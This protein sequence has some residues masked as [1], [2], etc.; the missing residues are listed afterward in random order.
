MRCFILKHYKNITWTKNK[1]SHMILNQKIKFIWVHKIWRH[2]NSQR[3]LIKSSQ[4]NLQLNKKWVFIYTNLNCHL[5]WKFIQYFM[6]IYYNSQ[7]M[8]QSANRYYCHNLQLSKTKKIC[9]L[10]T[11]L[12]TWNKTW[13]SHNLSSWSNEKNT[14]KELENH[15]QW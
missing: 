10:L 6:L 13:N 8:I 15:I 7:R 11:Q 9:I 2:N 5:K 1:Y 3:N 12:M 4:N 14:N